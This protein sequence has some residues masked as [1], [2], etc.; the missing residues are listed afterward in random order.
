MSPPYPNPETTLLSLLDKRWTLTCKVTCAQQLSEPKRGGHLAPHGPGSECSPESS[1]CSSHVHTS[2]AQA[3][4]QGNK[5]PKAEPGGLALINEGD[6]EPQE[7]LE[8]E[9]QQWGGGGGGVSVRV[10]VCVC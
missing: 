5:N 3:T 8:E 2:Q 7:G 4:S 9:G 10:C 6:L 1:L